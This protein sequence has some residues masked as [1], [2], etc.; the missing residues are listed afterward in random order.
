MG[1]AETGAK[2]SKVL[3]R[4]QSVVLPVMSN[5]SET[6]WT[7]TLFAVGEPNGVPGGLCA[8]LSTY[9]ASSNEELLASSL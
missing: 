2:G 3:G 4:D 9:V 8:G 7:T 1:G 6:V 5:P